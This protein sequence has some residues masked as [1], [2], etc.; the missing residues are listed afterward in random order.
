MDSWYRPLNEQRGKWVDVGKNGLDLGG[1]LH[2][3][4]KVGKGA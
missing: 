3:L 4:L 2:G 1:C